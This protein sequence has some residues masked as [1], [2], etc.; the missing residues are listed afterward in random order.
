MTQVG[1]Q[2]EIWSSIQ[3]DHFVISCV[4]D[5]KTHSLYVFFSKI[6]QKCTLFCQEER[7]I[8]KG[9]MQRP[10]PEH[11]PPHTAS[12]KVIRDPNTQQDYLTAM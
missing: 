7:N 2:V 4:I 9:G 6:L 5:I 3:I 1:G 12:H 11:T 10:L 8:Y